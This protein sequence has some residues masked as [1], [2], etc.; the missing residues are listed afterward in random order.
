MYDAG[1][2]GLLCVISLLVGIG[3]TAWHFLGAVEA[4][5]RD[6]PHQPDVE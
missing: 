2:V 5:G 4:T 6:G 1:T 3:L